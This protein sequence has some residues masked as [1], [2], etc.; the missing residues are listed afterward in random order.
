MP[1]Y[2]ELVR[3]LRAMLENRDGQIVH[4]AAIESAKALLARIERGQS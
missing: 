1:T 3:A 2:D 4:R